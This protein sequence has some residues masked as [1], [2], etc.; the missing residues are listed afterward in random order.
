MRRYMQFGSKDIPKTSQLQKHTVL[1]Q[2]TLS[3]YMYVYYLK[4][5]MLPSLNANDE[6][7]NTNRYEEHSNPSNKI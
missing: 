1:Q 7:D 2:R 4:G 3:A 6:Q 5:R